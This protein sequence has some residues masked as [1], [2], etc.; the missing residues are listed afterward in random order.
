MT[1]SNLPDFP[2]QM[3]VLLEDS[4]EHIVRHEDAQ[5]FIGWMCEHIDDYYT[6]PDVRQGGLF[7]KPVVANPD[8][9]ILEPDMLRAL[10]VNLA[11]MIWNSTPLPSNHFKPRPLPL[12]KRNDPCPCGSDKKYKQCCARLP[13][14]PSLTTDEIWP[15]LF[16]KLDKETAARAIRENH[17]PINAL[18]T[19]AYE[20]LESDQPKK[21]ATLLAPLFDGNI[22][23]TND[24]AEY[25]FTLLCNAYDEL[26]HNK[27]KTAL[28]L[29]I[30]DTVPR[31]PLR[32]GTWQRLS[33]IRMDSGDVNGAWAAFQHAQRDD[34][35][36]LSL[37]LL[38]V[39]ILN[40]Q[41]RNEKTRQRADFWVRQ[42]R[43][44]G[45]ADNEM[46]LAFLIEVARD[47]LEAF[48]DLGLGIVDDAGLLLKQ[49]LEEIQDRPLPEY[50]ICDEMAL[51]DLADDEEEDLEEEDCLHETSG[52]SL[53]PPGKLDKLE[54]DWHRIYPLD[55]P[56]SI[57]EAPYGDADPWDVFE[58]LEWASWL[59]DHP[60]A[61]DSLD[62]LDDL[63][64]ALMLHPQFGST[65][66]NETLLLPLL[67]RSE[68]ITEK[69]LAAAI[70]P[71]LHWVMPDNRPALRAMARLV[72]IK[73]IMEGNQEDA[74][75][76]A[77]RLITINP[78]DN[79]GF[80]S[81]VMNQLITKGRDEEALQL[82]QGYPG[83]MNPEVTYGKVLVLYRLGRQKEAVDELGNALEFLG[84]I[85]RYLTAKRSRK[86]KLHPDGVQYGGDDQAWYY[87]E[88][89]RD[90]W[91]QTPGALEWLKKA[92]KVFQ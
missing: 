49:C 40:A 9:V 1:H 74:L 81:D 91:L 37:G 77:Q 4:I 82:A 44:A 15:I 87:R 43:R 59:Q 53:H 68:A 80:R 92:V 55:K 3:E 88:E 62:I 79:H 51:T 30:I 34:P 78:H 2:L 50:S 31:S 6:G 47:P 36:S 86:P 65:W 33:T 8:Q 71:Q 29:Y 60:A 25:A 42:L 20:Y 72:N 75:S 63:A 52:M 18:S 22:R 73:A 39:Q 67:H 21:A 12:P 17:A 76:R 57:N 61:F 90:A 35:K 7:A 46:P 26:G 13:A 5:H 38:E 19:I 85:P 27:K 64:T 14:I 41:G 28:L 23:K 16:E 69:T 83:D 56:F 24:D 66:L 58:E 45:V 54:L 70:E 48:A 32:S 11:G 10:A 89:M 84:K